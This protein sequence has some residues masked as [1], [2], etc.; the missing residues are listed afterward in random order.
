MTLYKQFFCSAEDQV[1]WVSH[2]CPPVFHSLHV[3]L[4]L[5]SPCIC[6][7]PGCKS[8][9]VVHLGGP[10]LGITHGASPD[11]S[12]GSVQNHCQSQRPLVPG[13]TAV[14]QS[15]S[16]LSLTGEDFHLAGNTDTVK[17]L[18]TQETGEAAQYHQCLRSDR[19]YSQQCCLSEI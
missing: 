17:H 2:T 15:T 4:Q 14:L 1:N 16:L 8:S 13:H 6:P 5:F 3:D 10:Y 19:L 9:P 12:V 11:P 7:F 18:I